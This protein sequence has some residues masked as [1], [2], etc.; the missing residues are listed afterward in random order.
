MDRS[1]DWLLYLFRRAKFR[2]QGNTM[3]SY[4][5]I[6]QNFTKLVL[7]YKPIHVLERRGTSLASFLAAELLGNAALRGCGAGVALA[8]VVIC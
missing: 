7:F 3:W 1:A 5:S 2:V 4:F 6:L 8:S